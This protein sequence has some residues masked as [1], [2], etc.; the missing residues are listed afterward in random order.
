MENTGNITKEDGKKKAVIISAV[1]VV[2]VFILGILIWQSPYLQDVLGIKPIDKLNDV[3]N[4]TLL[5][6]TKKILSTTPYLGKTDV[7]FRIFDISMSKNGITPSEIVVNKGDRVQ[8]NFTPVDGKYDLNIKP[9]G[10]YLDPTPQGKTSEGSFDTLIAGDLPITCW[11]ACPPG[12]KSANL[13]V[14]Q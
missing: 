7:R 5:T 8:L 12:A 3:R 6:P 14:L 11:T 4:R 10:F 9:L 2:V 13:K 1:A